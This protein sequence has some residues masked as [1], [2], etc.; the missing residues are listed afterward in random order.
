MEGL[1]LENG[2]ISFNSFYIVI[3]YGGYVRMY[4]YMFYF[5]NILLWC[6]FFFVLSWSVSDYHEQNYYGFDSNSWI[7][8]FIEHLL[9]AT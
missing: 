8:L 1:K 5:I 3:E 2:F 6:I 7:K 4:M 9:L